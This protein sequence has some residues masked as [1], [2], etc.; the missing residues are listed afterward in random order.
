MFYPGTWDHE[1]GESQL[2]HKKLRQVYWFM[3]VSSITKMLYVLSP[4]FLALSVLSAYT[5]PTLKTLVSELL[6]Y[7]K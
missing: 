6:L 5:Y 3:Y 4:H 2:L 1:K 7:I